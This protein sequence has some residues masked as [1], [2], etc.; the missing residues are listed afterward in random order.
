MPP[1]TKPHLK[2][3]TTANKPKTTSTQKWATFTYIGKET[4]YIT[5]LFK[6][7]DLKIVMRNNNSIQ[8]TLMHNKELT[9]NTDKYMQCGVYKLTCPDCNKAYMGQTGRNFLQGLMNTKPHSEQT[10]KTKTL[11]NTSSSAHT[12]LA[13]SKTLQRQNKG[14]YL[15]TIERYYI[16]REYT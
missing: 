5:N 1:K 4:T 13:P 8:K 7:T 3:I 9:N 11:P 14:T 16:Y 6:N 2:K 15:N 12:L 10:A